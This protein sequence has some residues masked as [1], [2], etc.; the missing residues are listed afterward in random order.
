MAFKIDNA[1]TMHGNALDTRIP[2]G[3]LHLVD[4]NLI[5]LRFKCKGKHDQVLVVRTGACVYTE[6]KKPVCV[7]WSERD[8]KKSSMYE[9]TT[10]HGSS[11]EEKKCIPSLWRDTW[12]K[13]L[14]FT[15]VLNIVQTK[16]MCT[17]FCSKAGGRLSSFLRAFRLW[18]CLTGKWAVCAGCVLNFVKFWNFRAKNL[19][20]S[21][22][23]DR[24]QKTTAS[25]Q[26]LKIIPEQKPFEKW[27]KTELTCFW[28][29][30]LCN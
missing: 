9:C 21:A 19:R 5:L 29:L 1:T 26:A 14:W 22:N 11:I 25:L 12:R 10:V 24:A 4:R 6:G 3:Y 30:Q 8:S 23:K 17:L 13:C 27:D 20:A 15:S 28:R 18:P 16:L 7:L 2:R